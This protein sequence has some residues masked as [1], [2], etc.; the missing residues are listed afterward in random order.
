MDGYRYRY[1]VTLM[2]ISVFFSTSREIEKFAFS[3][4]LYQ[5]NAYPFITY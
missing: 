5:R 3:S 1:T 4:F 2:K